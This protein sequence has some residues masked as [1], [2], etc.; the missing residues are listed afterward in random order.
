MSE[1]H[2]GFAPPPSPP[3]PPPPP[4]P[5]SLPPELEDDDDP[6][7]GIGCLLHDKILYSSNESCR[8][9]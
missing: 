3:P 4:K 2:G 1:S 6:F 8:A 9:P 7:K 5:W